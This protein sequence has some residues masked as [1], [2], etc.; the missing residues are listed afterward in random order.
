MAFRFPS[1]VFPV[2]L[3]AALALPG[4]A[5]AEAFDPAVPLD[6]VAIGSGR[7]QPARL[8]LSGAPRLVFVND[9]ASLVRVELD[10][11]RGE[12]IACGGGGEPASRGRKFVV[13]NGGRLECEAPSGAVAYRVFRNGGGETEELR[14]SIEP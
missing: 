8:A 11:A 5:S 9:S 4:A 2:L 12:G 14:G 13:A 10:L 3:G 6:T 7:L 1:S